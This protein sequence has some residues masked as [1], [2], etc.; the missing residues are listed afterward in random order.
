MPTP[1]PPPTLIVWTVAVVVPAAALAWALYLARQVLVLI[2]VSVLLAI[3]FSPL[4]RL[5]ERQSVL[6]V[7]TRVPRWLAIL[8]V[9]LAILGVLAAIAFVVVP[10]FVTQAREFARHVPELV[11]RAERWSVVLGFL[12]ERVPWG[13]IVQQARGGGDVA[14]TVV[15]TFWGLFGGMLGVVSVVILPFYLLIDPDSVFPAIVGL[16]PAERRA[17]LNA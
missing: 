11:D 2:Y 7:G 4:V 16:F 5:I 17:R 8:I 6:Q 12:S 15:S 14:G 1:D 9:Y 3:G 13:Q 10:P